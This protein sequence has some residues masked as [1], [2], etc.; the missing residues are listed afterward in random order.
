MRDGRENCGL[1]NET[2]P[3]NLS[4]DVSSSCF[5]LLMKNKLGFILFHVANLERETYV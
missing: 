5:I 4:G 3:G 1:I 2:I